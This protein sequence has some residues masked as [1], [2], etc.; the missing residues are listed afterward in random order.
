[1]HLQR[2]QHTC[3]RGRPSARASRAK[4]NTIALD[5]GGAAARPRRRSAHAPR[6]RPLWVRR[7]TYLPGWRRGRLPH[8]RLADAAKGQPA[9]GRAA[10]AAAAA[11][12]YSP[13][14][15]RQRA[16]GRWQRRR[17]EGHGE[18]A[19]AAATRTTV[20]PFGQ[21]VERRAWGMRGGGSHELPAWAPVH[22]GADIA[23]SASL[24]HGKGPHVGRTAKVDSDQGVVLRYQDSVWLATPWS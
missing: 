16:P 2:L 8:R 3:R 11:D 15:R 10:S 1:M 20:A 9:R 21:R 14:A 18:A 12:R 13:P 17:R 19:A 22:P 5:L 7:P 4:Q 24:S 23:A 6:R